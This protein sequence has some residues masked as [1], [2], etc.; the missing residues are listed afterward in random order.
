MDDTIREE[1]VRV[2]AVLKDGRRIEVDVD[3]AIGSLQNP[4]SDA[5]LEAKFTPLVTPVLGEAKTREITQACW[6]LAALPDVRTLTAL[7]RP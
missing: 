4:L 1:Q 6:Q 5:Q 3:H 2:T 7:C